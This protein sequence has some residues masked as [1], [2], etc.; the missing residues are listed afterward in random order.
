MFGP[1]IAYVISH[2]RGWG[3]GGVCGGAGFY[4]F[5]GFFRGLETSSNSPPEMP[6][7]DGRLTILNLT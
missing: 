3:G 5:Y 6:E 4:R 1:T 7:M 2:Q